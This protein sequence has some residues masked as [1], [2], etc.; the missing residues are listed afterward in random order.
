MHDEQAMFRHDLRSQLTVIKN[1][2][3]FVIEGRT[4]EIP[5]KTGTF[6]KEALKRTDM[7]I[8]LTFQMKEEQGGK[9]TS[10]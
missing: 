6:L 5:E 9:H 7:L 3:S 10:G 2:L 8:S 4:G 1:A